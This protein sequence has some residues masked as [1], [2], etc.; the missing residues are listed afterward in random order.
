MMKASLLVPS[1]SGIARKLGQWMSVKSGWKAASTSAS[2][3]RTNMLRTNRLCH[4]VSV[5]TRTLSRYSG[6]A[7]E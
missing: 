6:S 2:N 4:A 5:I 7:P 3:S 1:R